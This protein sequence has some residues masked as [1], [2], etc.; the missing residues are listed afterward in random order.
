MNKK[1]KYILIATFIIIVIVVVFNYFSSSSTSSKEDELKKIEIDNTFAIWQNIAP[2]GDKQTLTQN[3]VSIK[4]DLYDKLTSPEI[5]SLKQYSTSIQNLL[6]VKNKPFDPLFL[7][8]LAYL[9]SNFNS[10]KE[11][12]SK[13]NA[14][15]ILPS[16]ILGPIPQSNYTNIT[17]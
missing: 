7:S 13:T 14:R 16:F 8:S 15:N 4:K 9:T 11:I 1:L 5:T 6:S 17:L 12:I 2:S 10:T 3:E